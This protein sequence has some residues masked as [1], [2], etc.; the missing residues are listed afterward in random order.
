M[1]GFL[2]NLGLLSLSIFCSSLLI[3]QDPTAQQ[4]A[5]DSAD[6]S[7]KKS[8]QDSIAQQIANDSI[9]HRI[10]LI[11][12]AGKQDGGKHP[13]LELIKKLYTLDKRTTVIFL[14]D[15]IYPKGLPSVYDKD[16][17]EMK[18]ILDSQI[19][20]VQNTEARAF[21]I[22][23]NHDWM[24]GRP[25]GWQQ[26]LN[27]A[28]YINSLN[29]P[30]VIYSPSDVCPGPEEIQLT[31][32]IT[33]V[34]IDSQWWLH[35]FEKPGVSYGCDI[36]TE[37]ELLDE[38][39][40][41]VNRNEDKLIIFA[42]H[43]PF[44]TYGRHGGYYS[45]KQHIFPFTEMN[46]KLYIP[47]P[48]LGSLYPLSRGVFGNIQ[49]NRHPVY[50]GFSRAVD[51][52]LKRHPYTIRVSGHEH[53][54]QLIKQDDQFYIVSGAGAKY[55]DL[56][57]GEDM[58]YG[59]SKTGF[60]VIDVS[61]RGGVYVSFYSSMNDTATHAL[62]RTNLPAFDTTPPKPKVYEVKNFPD[63]IVKAGNK[64]LTA[65]STKR[66]W[67]GDNYRD[68]WTTPVKAKVFDIGKEKGG[69]KITKLGGGMQTKS[70]RL[71]DKDGNEYVLRSVEKFPDN[72]LP[73]EFRQTIVR[74]AVV[75]GISA[76][77]PYAALSI[78]V[79]TDALGIPA[80]KPRLVYIP[81][82]PR[83]GYYRD[84]FA[85]SLAIF[86]EKE[87][88][89]YE[90]NNS[91]EKLIDKLKDDHD[92]QVDQIAVLK[93]RLL[94]MFIMDFDRHEDQWRWGTNDTGERKTFY[95]IPRD[96]D[97]AFFVNMG[98][99]PK[100]VSKKY[101]IP[102]FQGFRAKARDIN[103]FNFNARFFD[104]SFLNEVSKEDWEKY[105]DTVLNAMTPEVL[106]KA[107]RQQPKEI[108][109][110]SGPTIVKTLEERKKYFRDEALEYYKF[111]AKEVDIS[112][113]DKREFVQIDHLENG[114]I[115][116]TVR[117]INK[118]GDT[119]RVLYNRKFFK[120]ET[121]E[122]RMFARGGE[123]S[124]LV[125][126]NGGPI[127]V[128]II[129]GP[130][131]DYFNN[132]SSA[133]KR[134][135]LVY[136]FSPEENVLE[137][138][139]VRNKISESPFVNTYNRRTFKYDV[140][141]PSPTVEYNRDDGLYL[142]MSL[143]YQAHGFRKEPFK[144]LQEVS[145]SHA[146]ATKAFMYN[147]NLQLIDAIGHQDFVLSGTLRLPRNTINFFGL[148][149]ETQYDRSDGRSINYY[150]TRYDNA[151]IVAGLRTE[152]TSDI[153]LYYGGS[154]QY[155][156]YKNEYNEG[157]ILAERPFPNI[158]TSNL[159]NPKTY[160]GPK[161]RISIDNRNDPVIPSRGIRWITDAEM[162]YGLQ[163]TANNYAKLNTDLSIYISSNLPAKLVIA[164]RFG[165]GI[166]YGNYEY[167]QAQYLSGTHN[168]RGFRKFRFAGDKM[169]YNNVDVRYK[170]G[171]FRTYL[172]P[173]AYGIVAFHDVG[174]VWYKEERS[175]TWHNGYGL[176]IWIAPAK[177]LV[178]TA[179]FAHSKDGNMPVLSLGYHF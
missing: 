10:I 12:D 154:F 108:Y 116:I 114:D 85:N 161:M 131:K 55:S 170:I 104:R 105:V 40:D 50:K 48:L 128:R 172:L 23:G 159:S 135:T 36:R 160:I 99:I 4:N 148:G 137:G 82:D 34:T 56:S 11:G 139:A 88:G 21:F 59:T 1:K 111:L 80:A 138:N 146:L 150:R 75:D 14:G 60:G 9:A 162:N 68:E 61:K 73:P 26:I 29:R 124:I 28:R 149:N 63:S 142:G 134:K 35:R 66:W 129:G 157:K 51:S 32:E 109:N 120:E 77:Y 177:K 98:F 37:E 136:D 84:E 83:L 153:N 110:I 70:L 2:K 67:L 31:S 90:K 174:R 158:D 16:Y 112:T 100:Q 152:L 25:G 133:P 113:S 117:K 103:T 3:A 57:K 94:D 119:S 121:D 87:P 22:A 176:G 125:T 166:T 19:N 171:E 143:K 102:K 141:K 44:I 72:T 93:A 6:K 95:P 169:F 168:L 147:Y 7:N 30:N 151:E 13:E 123:D 58:L 163:S 122:I 38:L 86:E 173:A 18:Q 65:N 156:Y 165:G 81:D 53:S 69:L 118:E 106:D 179:S 41:I 45:L 79:F 167:F 54:L 62:Y 27:Q 15:N 52:I 155:F 5:K 20:L 33:L 144:V 164:L 91:T 43:H 8:V 97:Q 47:L 140:L 145:A 39:K 24:Q 46:P 76:S 71:E 101:R 130:G 89:G 49:D 127:K 92:N 96:R 175:K 42:A 107:L 78:P 115:E 178:A 74:D 17:P 64:K 132:T 126:G